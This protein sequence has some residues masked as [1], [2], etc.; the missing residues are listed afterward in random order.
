MNRKSIISCTT[1][2]LVAGGLLLAAGATPAM[3]ASGA[4]EGFR[5]VATASSP[6]NG[7]K[8]KVTG[9]QEGFRHVATVEGT[10]ARK[11][12]IAGSQDG[13]RWL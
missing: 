3:A 6:Q 9:A 5:H 1:S 4:Q 11:W 12:Q 7:V 13:Q 8:W 2:A 10:D